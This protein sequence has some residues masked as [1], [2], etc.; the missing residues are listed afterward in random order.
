MAE[1]LASYCE[2]ELIVV[3]G[4]T[5]NEPFYAPD[6]AYWGLILSRLL[7]EDTEQ[8]AQVDLVMDM[9]ENQPSTVGTTVDAQT[10]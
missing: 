10:D 7:A 3:P 4:M 8:A 9:P 6:I 5:H 2:S 1:E